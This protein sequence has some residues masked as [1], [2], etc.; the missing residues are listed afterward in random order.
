MTLI[1]HFQNKFDAIKSIFGLTG[2]IGETTNFDNYRTLIE[3][4]ESECGTVNDNG[5]R[6]FK[7]FH[8]LC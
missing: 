4:F 1:K 2:E 3:K 8:E 6:H 7:Y 5:L